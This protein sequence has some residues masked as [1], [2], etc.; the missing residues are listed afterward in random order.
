MCLARLYEFALRL[1]PADYHARF[2]SEMVIAFEEAADDRCRD[3]AL[4]ALRFARAEATSLILGIGREWLA[5]VTSDRSWRGR[6]LPDCRRMRPP[7]V[8]PQ[9]WAAGLASIK[10][11]RGGEHAD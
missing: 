7:G 2:A 4:A 9:Q 10:V 8:T 1:Y 5:K 3:G 11:Q 6:Y